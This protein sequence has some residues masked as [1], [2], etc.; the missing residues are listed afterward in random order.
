[1]RTI[2][3]E[4]SSKKDLEIFD[5][6]FTAVHEDFI[7][8]LKERFPSLNQNDLRLCTFL[9]MNKTTKEIASLMNMSIRGVETSRYRLRKKMGLDKD[10]NLY[11]I[12]TII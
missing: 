12:I 1:M 11:D 7:K 8:I 5:L 2:D 3:S 6:N 4:I 10:G 9:K